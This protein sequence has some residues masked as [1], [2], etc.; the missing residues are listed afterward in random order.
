MYHSF[1]RDLIIKETSEI[2]DKGMIIIK[3]ILQS[4]ILS[5]DICPI[6]KAIGY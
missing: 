6:H 3:V 5:S 2:W 1:S 4:Q